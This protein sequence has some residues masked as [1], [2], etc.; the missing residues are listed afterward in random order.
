[1]KAS[2]HIYILQYTE[3]WLRRETWQYPEGGHAGGFYLET[4]SVL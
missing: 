4:K 1:M 2:E 3:I